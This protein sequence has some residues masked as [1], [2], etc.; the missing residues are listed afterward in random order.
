MNISKSSLYT[1]GIHG[2]ELNE[3]QE[4][5]N[6]LRGTMSFHYLGISLAAKNLKV[7]YFALLPLPPFFL[8]NIVA[9]ISKWMSFSL[10]YAGRAEFV[11]VIFQGVECFLGLIT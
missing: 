11:R 5:T 6:I 2:Q 3:I 9:Y 1:I 8:D 10:S 7:G 4:S